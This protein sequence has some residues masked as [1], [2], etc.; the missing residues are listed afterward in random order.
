MDP[1]A[2]EGVADGQGSSA[3]LPDGSAFHDPSSLQGP[4]A[5]PAL[6]HPFVLVIT[7][8]TFFTF[9]A[10]WVLPLTIM[11]VLAKA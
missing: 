6:R 7:H 9:L 1:T 10:V 11:T 8:L 2:P 5:L 4:A 3:C